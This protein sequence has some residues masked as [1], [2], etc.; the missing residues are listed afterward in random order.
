[1]MKFKRLLGQLASLLLTSF[2]LSTVAQSQTYSGQ[3]VMERYFEAPGYGE[4]RSDQ[5]ASRP[6]LY[7]NQP[8][9]LPKSSADPLQTRVVLD[10]VQIVHDK[11][12]P[13][14]GCWRIAGELAPAETARHHT[15]WILFAKSLTPSK[16]CPRPAP[17]QYLRPEPVT[18]AT[19]CSVKNPESFTD[20]WRRF[21]ATA[22]NADC[23]GLAK[24]A[25]KTFSSHGVLDSDPVVLLKQATIAKQCPIWLTAQDQ[26]DAQSSS[27]EIFF[28]RQATPPSGWRIDGEASQARVGP[29]QFM[30]SRGCWKWLRYYRP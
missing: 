8:Q 17:R 11:A 18:E 30:Q 12:H 16:D 14:S 24:L 1:M 2:G 3:I 23:A 20:F 26:I 10:A 22:L 4:S 15:D 9:A 25:S 29:L 13:Q 19:M 5:A 28:R 21:R 7:F 27:L 6:V